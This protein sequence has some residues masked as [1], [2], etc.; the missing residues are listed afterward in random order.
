M[1]Q[2]YLTHDSKA[3]VNG[4]Q[5]DVLVQQEPG[6]RRV[7]HA[8]TNTILPSVDVHNHRKLP[9]IISWLQIAYCHHK[10]SQSTVYKL[11]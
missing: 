11:Y 3:I 10:A 5:D 2:Q 7:A 4:D 9:S 8:G 1:T 6:S